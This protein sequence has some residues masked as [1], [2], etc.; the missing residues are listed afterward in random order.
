[1]SW[2]AR[3][4][5][6]EL[7]QARLCM[8]PAAAPCSLQATSLPFYWDALNPGSAGSADVVISFVLPNPTDEPQAIYLSRIGNGYEISLNGG[9]VERSEGWNTPNGPDFAKQPRLI[10]LPVQSGLAL[11]RLAKAIGD[12]ACSIRSKTRS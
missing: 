3:A 10:T 11:N 5:V 12:Q 7:V 1:M 9:L 6:V 4:E 8:R 2:P